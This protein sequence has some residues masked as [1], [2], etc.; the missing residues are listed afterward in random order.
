M[1]LPKT[2]SG[3]VLRGTLKKIIDGDEYK[4]PATIED[5]SVL[6]QIRKI[7]KLSGLGEKS[8]LVYQ[9]E[10]DCHDMTHIVD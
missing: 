1:N 10:V 8:D 3:K 9:D 7:V 4:M 2:R 6:E 5:E